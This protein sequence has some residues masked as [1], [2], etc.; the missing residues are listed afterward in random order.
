M[1]KVGVVGAGAF[2]TALAISAA[3]QNNSV[4]LWGRSQAQINEIKYLKEKLSLFLSRLKTRL[5]INL[6]IY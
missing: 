3:S 1:R 4:I 6:P 2:G 5:L